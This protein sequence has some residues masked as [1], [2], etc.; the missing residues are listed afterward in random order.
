MRFGVFI[1]LVVS[2]VL[3]DQIVVRL[4]DQMVGDVDPTTGPDLL[5]LPSI[6]DLREGT[7]RT[8][9]NSS[10]YLIYR[11]QFCF[12]PY[13]SGETANDDGWHLVYHKPK[14]WLSV[15]MPARHPNSFYFQEMAQGDY[16]LFVKR[17][18]KTTLGDRR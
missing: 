17:D 3:L 14:P 12:V 5:P 8:C 18:G 11:Y 16:V 10:I 4:A 13:T 2:V 15:A 7:K 9:E 1:G 6:E